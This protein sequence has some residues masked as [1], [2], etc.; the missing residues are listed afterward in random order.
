[1][2]SGPFLSNSWYRVAAIRPGLRDHARI[3]R[4]RYRGQIF[5]VVQDRATGQVH[6]LGPA[7]YQLVAAMDGRRTVEELWTDAAVNLG[8]DAPSQDEVI[9]LLTQLHAADLLQGNYPPDTTELFS[10]FASQRRSRIWRLLRNPMSLN[11]SL[12]DPDAFLGKTMHFVRPLF[13][14]WGST[15]WLLLV[16][17]AIVLAAQHWPELSEDASDHILAADNLLL[18]SLSYPIIK[19]L[20]ELGH[21][22][23]IKAFGGEVHDFGV[24]FLVLFPVPYVDA[25]ASSA[26]RSKRRRALVGA[27][28][29]LVE[30]ALAAIALYFWLMVEPG[31]L[32][33][34]AFNVM[35]IAGVSTVLFNGNPL[36]RFDGYYVLSDLLEIPNLSMR[37]NRY[38]GHLIDRYIF[39]TE[40]AKDFPATQGE[41]V[42][43][44]AYAP[45]AGAYRFAVMMG[46]ALFLSTSYMMVGVALAIW[47]VVT[48]IVVPVTKAFWQIAI[49]PRLRQNR[50]WATGVTGGAIAVFILVLFCVPAPMHTT[51]EGII[52]LPETSIVRAGTN[53]FVQRLLVKSGVSVKTGV[54]LIESDEPE[55]T[56]Q[57]GKLHGRVSELEAEYSAERLSDRVRAAITETELGQASAEVERAEDRASRLVARSRTDGIFTQANAE[58]LPGRYFHEGEIL[59]FVLPPRS[60]TIRAVILQDNIDLV[61]DRLTGVSAKLVDHAADTYPVQIV[62]A[63]PAGSD[64]LPS[65]ALGSAGGGSIAVDPRDRHAT[66]ALRRVFQIDLELLSEAPRGVFGS[67]VYVRFEHTWEPLGFQI[68]RR[69]RQLV[70]SRL[71]A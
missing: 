54:P 27:A 12:W 62:R 8:E 15:L 29:I 11:F 7:T 45:I 17:P 37:S 42:W 65:K 3:R 4:H 69:M 21:G 13:S 38:W 23:A 51:G 59:G 70:L 14:W 56:M 16:L 71:E 64:E 46:V 40:T 25:T 9:S 50:G 36:L 67:R 57:L 53:G 49:S 10:R 44:L 5:Y 63:V 39:R 34:V 35:L 19:L 33:A 2:T 20:H 66:K 6:R 30:T 31:L 28:G 58:D 48:S 52:W 41:R 47:T 68:Y 43:F 1:V 32:R 26:F 61:R 60:Q 24:M 55:L 22:F 18:I